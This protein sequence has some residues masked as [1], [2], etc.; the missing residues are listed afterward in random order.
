MVTSVFRLF[1]FFDSRTRLNH[2]VNSP[3]Q[4]RCTFNLFVRSGAIVS[5]Q[6]N[7]TLSQATANYKAQSC[8]MQT[9]ASDAS[10]PLYS[11]R[12]SSFLLR[13]SPKKNTKVM[14][15]IYHFISSLHIFDAYNLIE[16]HFITFL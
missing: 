1:G 16:I 5:S 10:I 2:K 14:N 15:R 11:K 13:E 4:E 7:P 8:P 6:I 3:V 9:L 12:S